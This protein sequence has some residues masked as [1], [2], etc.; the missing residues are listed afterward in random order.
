MACYSRPRDRRVA[1]LDTEERV[2]TA[3]GAA[4]LK[5]YPRPCPAEHVAAFGLALLRLR[6]HPALRAMPERAIDRLDA[7]MRLKF[8]HESARYR[9]ALEG[10]AAIAAG[11][12]RVSRWKTGRATK[13]MARAVLHYWV[14]DVCVECEGRGYG[15]V[16]GTPMLSDRACHVCGGRGVRPP[17]WERPGAGVGD[18]RAARHKAVL[19]ELERLERIAME[20]VEEVLGRGI[21]RAWLGSMA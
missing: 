2:V 9:E 6:T 13:D 20:V 4:D 12:A 16:V 10:V 8:C 21:W 14:C 1:K 18:Q 3:L 15:R 17:P 7:M 19:C 11:M 5:M